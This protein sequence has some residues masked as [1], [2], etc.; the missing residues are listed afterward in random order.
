MPDLAKR[1]G[2]VVGGVAIVFD[3]Q[4][5]HDEMAVSRVR[6]LSRGGNLLG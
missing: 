1:L 5:T 6:D 3:D 2:Q 4:E